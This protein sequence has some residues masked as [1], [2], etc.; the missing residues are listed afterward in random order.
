MANYANNGGS[1]GTGD[2]WGPTGDHAAAGNTHD[3]VDSNF[4][5]NFE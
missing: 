3:N 5:D 4:Q 1:W 2:E